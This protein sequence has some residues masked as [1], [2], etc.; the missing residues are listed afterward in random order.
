[1]FHCV[2]LSFIEMHSATPVRDAKLVSLLKCHY[3]ARMARVLHVY[4]CV[5]HSDSECLHILS[6]QASRHSRIRR[7]HGQGWGSLWP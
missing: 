1:M 4:I 3:Q 7:H 6:V 2:A 5:V